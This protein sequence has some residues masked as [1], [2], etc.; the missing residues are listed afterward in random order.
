MINHNTMQFGLIGKPLVH[1][2]SPTYF[3][4]KFKNENID[5]VYKAYEI[6]SIDEF[7][8]LVMKTDFQGLN[9][10]IPYKE[11]IIPF[12]DVVSQEAEEIGAVN[13]IVFDGKK[14]MGHNTDW[15]G[16]RQTIRL[17]CENTEVN[18]A[19]I[20][21]TGGASKAIQYVLETEGIDYLL[22]SR[23]KGNLRYS[24]IS[25]ETI[26]NH[27]LIINT[28]PLGTYPEIDK[29]PDIPYQWL[30]SNHRLFDLVYNPR[31]S[32]FLKNGV[33]RGAKVANGYDMLVKQAEAAW[34][35]FG[36]KG[37]N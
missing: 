36:I 9:V 26:Q 11:S 14:M 12:L 4:K 6:D 21:G 7:P 31:N 27:Q 16:A 20:L 37:S 25:F 17:L 35:L 19:L 10:T 5:A 22:V 18:G 32:L 15:I 8:S 3:T 23:T 30:T 13:T 33:I 1:S 34:E 28:T 24:D 2:F 29:A